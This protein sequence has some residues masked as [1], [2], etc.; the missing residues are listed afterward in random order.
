[1]D[2][3]PPAVAAAS[4]VSTSVAPPLPPAA[5]PVAP[6]ALNVPPPSVDPVRNSR[7]RS[8]SFNPLFL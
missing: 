8:D 4:V 1:M 6:T 3:A 5:V 2:T 7:P